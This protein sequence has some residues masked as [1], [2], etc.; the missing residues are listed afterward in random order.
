MI[1]FKRYI[2][3]V[4]VQFFSLLPDISNISHHV[5]LYGL[6]EDS[7][8]QYVIHEAVPRDMMSS[9][10]SGIINKSYKCK[11]T[12]WGYAVRSCLYESA[13]YIYIYTVYSL[14]SDK[15]QNAANP[16]TEDG[17]TMSH[18][19]EK[20][21]LVFVS[22]ALC[23]HHIISEHAQVANISIWS[24]LLNKLCFFKVGSHFIR[25]QETI[26]GEPGISSIALSVCNITS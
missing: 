10:F 2:E 1:L 17:E 15:K 24:S 26:S 6:S 22:L 9:S 25:V 13:L 4:S 14:D 11:N 5:L 8:V 19:L 20:S 16:H 3:D 23:L 18:W 7:N 12:T 21:S